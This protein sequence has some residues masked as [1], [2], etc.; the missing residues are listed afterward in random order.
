MNSAELTTSPREQLELLCDPNTFRPLRSGARTSVDSSS[1][2]GDGVVAGAGLVSGRPVYCYSQ[3]PEVLGGSLGEVHAES[4]VRTLE[5]AGETGAPVVG[6]ARSGG[7]RI[8]EG[9]AA[10]VGYGRI[11]R[12]S[13]RLKK[14]VP[15]ISIVSGSSAGGGAYF[16]ALTD[17]VLMSQEGRLF[18]TGPR[19]VE[20]AT[21]Q[22]VT[23]EALGGP[24]VHQAN[25]VCHAA[26][27]DEGAAVRLG[28][29]LLS[30]LPQR[31][32]SAPVASRP[33]DPES[34]GLEATVPA[35]ANET[36]DI[37]ATVKALVDE[38]SSIELCARWGEALFTGFTRREGRAVATAAIQQKPLN[39]YINAEA[40]EKAAIFVSRADRFGFPIV[41]LVDTPGF[42]PGEAQERAGVLRHG[43]SLLHAFSAAS[44]PRISVVL[45]K[46]YGGASVAMNSRALGADVA[47][48]WPTAEIGIMPAQQAIELV[49]RREIRSNGESRRKL[50]QGY[51]AEHLT[52]DSAAASGF[53]DEVISPEETR[54][55]ISWALSTA[56]AS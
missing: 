50:A 35:D 40:A 41:A 15:Q 33:L 44:V 42:L 45:R 12:E 51:A 39:G 10:L 28:Q 1:I 38:G 49:H 32:G 6:F 11:F 2:P 27:Q 37:R 46:A 4:I 30:L 5:L 14:R 25:G 31:V 7:A 16:P 22:T 26:T 21:G 48:A 20:G 13:V 52:A 17:F 3:D 29:R 24:D 55:A 53:V 18:V 47:F 23:M 34:S 36:Y 54:S 9:H 19:V 56:L 43:A 8:Q